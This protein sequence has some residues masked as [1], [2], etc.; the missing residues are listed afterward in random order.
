M[1]Y[2][3]D[4]F[5]IPSPDEFDFE[6]EIFQDFDVPKL[7][8][9]K[10][11]FQPKPEKLIQFAEPLNYRNPLDKYHNDDDVEFFETPSVNPYKENKMSYS[12][13]KSS[14]HYVDFDKSP[15]PNEF[16]RILAPG[17]I[18]SAK[19]N[20]FD[21]DYH[22][23]DS[24]FDI[25]KI[26][27]V[28]TYDEHVF[29]IADGVENK[30]G[31]YDY[32]YDDGENRY[33]DDYD[34]ENDFVSPV[35]DPHQVKNNYNHNS[36]P[37]QHFKR[38]ITDYTG[39]DEIDYNDVEYEPRPASGSVPAPL[40]PPPQIIE[41][42]HDS[43]FA[44]NFDVPKLGVPTE[45]KPPELVYN[46]MFEGKH[47]HSFSD[48]LPSQRLPEKQSRS[49]TVTP[50][51]FLPTP[52]RQVL[53]DY[54]H[55][56]RHKPSPVTV[57]PH[58]HSSPGRDKKP[59]SYQQRNYFKPSSPPSLTFE[60][61][62]ELSNEIDPENRALYQ[63]LHGGD[64]KYTESFLNNIVEN[65]VD[66]SDFSIPRARQE[67]PQRPETVL[68]PSSNTY[69]RSEF[70]VDGPP[71]SKR[72]QSVDYTPQDP[73]YY[74]YNPQ[75]IVDPY[76]PEPYQPH[77][78]A[79]YSYHPTQA[80][81]YPQ[82]HHH[83][84]PTPAPEFFSHQLPEFPPPD[85]YLHDEPQHQDYHNPDYYHEYKTYE[86]DT[87]SHDY[88]QPAFIDIPKL[89]AEHDGNYN[90]FVN[91]AGPESYEHG[92]VRGNPEHKKQEYTRREGRHFKSQVNIY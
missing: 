79:P 11:E 61:E 38:E 59:Q 18:N 39:Y 67:Q 85:N 33:F 91:V 28:E 65:E 58:S 30:Y 23:Y 19:E 1:R 83:P 53:T 16:P 9:K 74:D 22:Q 89:G 92:H 26:G 15:S 25:P 48:L 12:H 8:P 72:Y 40:P 45:Y 52:S 62:A 63:R 76:P 34:H 73:Y 71:R 31:N 54:S 4:Y 55:L 69:Q 84:Q 57:S 81:Y 41:M 29:K 2:Q 80:P 50:S 21:R 24:E 5:E 13:Y 10:R 36:Y 70:M 88:S 56:Y 75:K 6:N 77:T 78:P 44:G 90:Q 14:P 64:D 17:A 37:P 86:L 87:Y 27:P 49:L 20:S 51:P 60:S 35:S 43:V 46:E 7:K 32:N 3:N 82:Q 66:Y 47:R 42:Q 68:P